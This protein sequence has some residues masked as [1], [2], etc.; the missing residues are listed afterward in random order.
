MLE[1][2][3]GQW[4]DLKAK[5]DFI[6]AFKD[7][8]PP[9]S[10]ACLWRQQTSL[11]SKAWDIWKVLD[12]GFE[13]LLLL[14]SVGEQSH[15]LTIIEMRR[16]SDQDRCWDTKNQRGPSSKHGRPVGWL[17]NNLRTIRFPCP[18][19]PFSWTKINQSFVVV[20]IVIGVKDQDD[21]LFWPDSILS[22]S[23]LQLDPSGHHRPSWLTLKPATPWQ[24]WS[25]GDELQAKL[26]RDQW[27]W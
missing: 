10:I 4:L 13:N 11:I 2:Q 25:L 17:T 12:W 9:W 22:E 27:L 7:L 26:G 1:F 24:R 6:Q 16:E 19:C 20:A 14:V 8:H 23:K 5:L 3:E 21:P 18:N 15:R